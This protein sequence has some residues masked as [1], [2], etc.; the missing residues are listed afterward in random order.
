MPP[1]L[2]PV[3]PAKGDEKAL[4]Y[5]ASAALNFH[6]HAGNSFVITLPACVMRKSTVYKLT[7]GVATSSLTFRQMEGND[8]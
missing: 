8:D 1:A 6:S 7:H 4:S 5:M 2:S 3:G